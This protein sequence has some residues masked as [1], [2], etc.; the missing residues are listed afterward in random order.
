[1]KNYAFDVVLKEISEITD[2]QADAL[3][4]AGC[5]DGTPISRNSVAW[6]HFDR[7]ATTLEAAIQSAIAQI[8]TAGLRIAKVELDSDAAVALGA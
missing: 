6:V 4:A 7:E 3:F 2:D 8:Q 5:D 1:M